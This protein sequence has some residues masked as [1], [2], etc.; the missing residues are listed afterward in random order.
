[1]TKKSIVLSDVNE[2]SPLKAV[3]TLEKKDDIRGSVRFYNLPFE[4]KS[5]LTLGFY[6]DGEVIK[7]GLTEKGNSYYTFFL[8]KDIIDKK[9][10]CAI[11]SF[12]DAEPKPLLYGSS[13]G[14][15]EDIYAS[16]INELSAEKSAA[17][18]QKVLDDYGVDFDD[19]EKAEIEKEIDECMEENKC[20]NCFYKK[21]F[22]NL[23]KEKEEIFQKKVE[24]NAFFDEKNN[25]KSEVID[26]NNDNAITKNDDMEEKNEEAFYWRLKP[27]IDKLFANNPIEKNLEQIIPSS[28]FV[29]VEYE[30]D[31]D[32]YVFGLLYEGDDIK[33][34]CYGVP[35]IYEEVPPKELGGYPVFL[36]L[37]KNNEKGF[38]YWLTYQDAET[39][40]PIKAVME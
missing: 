40:E 24:K 6:V 39:G 33:Y 31:G 38:G 8:T 15:E 16:I 18:V 21:E 5:L 1:M 22:Y 25:E 14:R 37:D 10:S 11:I 17:K 20:V 2:N 32:F 30:D 9:F 34:V 7:S 26:E 23:K 12:K 29:K 3:L 13:D 35:A 28:K 27:Q 4:L 36:P 19:E